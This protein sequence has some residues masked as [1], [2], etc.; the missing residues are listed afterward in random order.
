MDQLLTSMAHRSCGCCG[1]AKLPAFRASPHL[2]LKRPATSTTAAAAAAGSPVAAAAKSLLP[3]AQGCVSSFRRL[4]SLASGGP[5]PSFARKRGAPQRGHSPLERRHSGALLSEALPPPKGF[6]LLHRPRSRREKLKH[7]A[8][9]HSVPLHLMPLY[10]EAAAAVA[11]GS[12]AGGARSSPLLKTLNKDKQTIHRLVAA[13]LQHVLLL[14]QQGKGAPKRS[15]G[16]TASQGPPEAAAAAAAAAAALWEIDRQVA[17]QG[18][19][20]QLTGAEAGLLLAA[21]QELLRPSL[22]RWA[23]A[24]A[25]AATATA[26]PART[27]AAAVAQ[28][29]AATSAPAA[30]A[31]AASAPA[32]A[33]AAGECVDGLGVAS[34]LLASPLS[35]S[36]FEGLR[37]FAEVGEGL[38][39]RV[40]ARRQRAGLYV[41]LAALKE[42]Q[43]RGEAVLLLQGLLQQ[44]PLITTTAAAAA[45][46]LRKVDGQLLPKLLQQMQRQNIADL[47]PLLLARC[48]HAA[49]N[50]ALMKLAAAAAAGATAAAAATAGT[51]RATAAAAG[52]EGPHERPGWVEQQHQ[53]QEAPLSAS[54]TPPPAFAAAAAEAEAAAK[55]VRE[56]V[57]RFLLWIEEGWRAPPLL[58]S[59]MHASTVFLLL[60]SLSRLSLF[61]VASWSHL[62]LYTQTHLLHFS[63]EALLAL[64]RAFAAKVA[65]AERGATKGAPG[66]APRE[67]PQ[68]VGPPNAERGP[69][70]LTEELK[71]LRGLGDELGKAA[72]AGRV[73]WGFAAQALQVFGKAGVL[74]KPMVH[75]LEHICA[76]LLLRLWGGPLGMEGALCMRG[77]PLLEGP[78]S[79]GSQENPWGAPPPRSLSIICY[80]LSKALP[81]IFEGPRLS[82]E[83]PPNVGAPQPAASRG[84]PLQRE[85]LLS[86]LTREAACAVAFF[87][88]P[89]LANTTAAVAAF[90]NFAAA[91]A[92]HRGSP[93]L[94][95]KTLL[96]RGPPPKP[97]H[98]AATN[99]MLAEAEEELMHWVQHFFARTEERL[100]AMMQAGQQLQTPSEPELQPYKSTAAT[101]AAAT[102]AAAAAGTAT[103]AGEHQACTVSDNPSGVC[104][105][106]PQA[107]SSNVAQDS[108]AYTSQRPA[109]AA[110]AGGKSSSSLEPQEEQQQRPRVRLGSL[111][112]QPLF[113]S[114]LKTNLKFSNFYQ[115]TNQVLGTG[116]S[117]AVCVGRQKTTGRLVAVKTLNIS[118]LSVHRAQ[119]LFNEV[120]VYL[121]LDHPNIAKLLDV[122]VEGFDPA[123]LNMK[124]PAS[125]SDSSSSSKGSKCIR[126]VMELCSGG[127]L[128]ERL[129][130]KKKYSERDAS[131]IARQMLAAINYCHQRNVCHR[132]LKLENWVYRDEREGSALKL[133][134]FGFSWLIA[135][136]MP[137]KDLEEL[138]SLFY[139]LDVEGRGTIRVEGLVSTLVERLKIPELEARRIF[140]R[141]DQTG[142]EEINYSEFLAATF[143]TQVALS[144]SLIREAFERLDADHSGQISLENL[145]HVLGDSYGG[146]L[147]EQ[148]LA[149][150]DLK[151]NGVIEFDE[152]L[153]ALLGS[154]SS[155]QAPGALSSLAR[156]EQSEILSQVERNLWGL[157][158]GMSPSKPALELQGQQQ[159]EEPQEQQ[160]EQQEQQQEE[161]R[162]EQQQQQQQQQQQHDEQNG[163]TSDEAPAAEPSPAAKAAAATAAA[164]EAVAAAEVQ[165]EAAT[166]TFAAAAAAAAAVEQAAAT[167]A[168]ATAAAEAAQAERVAAVAVEKAVAAAAA[169]E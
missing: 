94:L 91:A 37:V 158:D 40:V 53:Q 78:A 20:H 103:A 36:D 35:P 19:Q 119:L 81:L 136:S 132:D 146:L 167:V 33:A 14:Q 104:T 86:L 107:S 34:P 83:G 139:A 70:T 72:H 59:P 160:E 165:R 31:A 80:S 62:A 98:S 127:E 57:E 7:R 168:E 124:P 137:S 11:A 42:L 82:E 131:R 122:F 12:A 166:K 123:E 128:Y 28:A 125:P 100:E 58:P 84:P 27:A 63:P 45:D 162:Q 46:A 154:E 116:V 153:V 111:Q 6:G 144:Q 169:A 55:G 1:R 161:S 148:I 67:A 8:A 9:L 110:A 79:S 41:H 145:R 73:S 50:P 64:A 143:Q 150:C 157:A 43:L 24:A 48:A 13:A 93:L 25:A 38:L 18:L 163:S 26:T 101:A 23:R 121:Q 60:V 149:Q 92:D 118:R 16:P 89:E 99:R 106:T 164:A 156:A 75:A 56:S 159:Q 109:A 54:P 52:D 112:Q 30:A 39:T 77:A 51:A 140:Q 71:V 44:S 105:A 49:T 87:G 102:T 88:G 69:P 120:A 97:S 113:S 32:A 129:A 135:L 4:S 65:A 151:K 130:K 21:R 155:L 138:E 90:A 76:L 108:S 29:A 141:I 68:G 10:E 15:T 152:F 96:K 117:G 2:S 74:H 147:V 114:R 95:Q 85:L 17:T 134:D 22:K 61:F 5:L 47:N 133:I 142:D 3:A 66:R 115:L 126:L